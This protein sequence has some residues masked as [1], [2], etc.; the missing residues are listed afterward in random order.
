MLIPSTDEDRSESQ[1]C[2]LAYVN[3]LVFFFSETSI[4]FT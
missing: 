2:I 1:S 4:D 3:M